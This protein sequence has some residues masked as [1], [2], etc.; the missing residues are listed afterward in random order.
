M[1]T[2]WS[3][4]KRTHMAT[5]RSGQSHGRSQRSS[6]LTTRG[7]GLRTPRQLAASLG[8]EK[9]TSQFE[10]CAPLEGRRLDEHHKLVLMGKTIKY[11]TPFKQ[12]VL[13]C[14]IRGMIKKKQDDKPISLYV[15]LSDI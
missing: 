14:V 5:S 3:L 2:I 6:F 7:L 13:I 9:E 8:H 10:R 12:I 11:W 4:E 1:R 15:T